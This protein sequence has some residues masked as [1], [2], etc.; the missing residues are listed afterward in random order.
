MTRHG[1]SLSPGCC[2]PHELY[3]QQGWSIANCLLLHQIALFGQ[4]IKQLL[5]GTN[6]LF[7]HPKSN[8][9]SWYILIFKVLIISKAA[10]YSFIHVRKWGIC[11]PRGIQKVVLL[12]GGVWRQAFKRRSIPDTCECDYAEF[13]IIAPFNCLWSWIVFLNHK[14][15]NLM[16]ENSYS[17]LK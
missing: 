11:C 17:Q 16:Q 2:H 14:L 10:I 1:Y 12:E 7:N 13:H 15:F 9:I 8:T 4:C 5:Q 3:C 6:W